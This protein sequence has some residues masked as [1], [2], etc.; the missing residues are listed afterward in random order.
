M[1][2]KF[3]FR[4]HSQHFNVNSHERMD[5]MRRTSSSYAKSNIYD[6][7]L[8]ET[9]FI[10]EGTFLHVCMFVCVYV[11]HKN[12]CLCMNKLLQRRTY[13]LYMIYNMKI[14]VSYKINGLHTTA[15]GQ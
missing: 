1:W 5:M 9:L 8:E 3:M 12:I 2:A 11:R 7:V 4:H 13:K 15:K 10:I 6:M 14:I